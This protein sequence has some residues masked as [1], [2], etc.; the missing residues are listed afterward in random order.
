MIPICRT[1]Y[2]FKKKQAFLLYCNDKFCFMKKQLFFKVFLMM[3][4]DKL[5]SNTF[6]IPI[7]FN[8]PLK[9]YFSNKKYLQSKDARH[10]L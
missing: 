6:C 8:K 1:L 2:S 9:A 10:K 7:T 3:T 4:H 5:E